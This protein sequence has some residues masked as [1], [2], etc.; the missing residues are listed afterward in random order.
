[1][2]GTACCRGLLP[3]VGVQRRVS[4]RH[5]QRT[6]KRSVCDDST[7]GWSA[8]L[9]AVRGGGLPLTI[10]AATAL[11]SSE[12][13]HSILECPTVA[14]VLDFGAVAPF[15]SD[16]LVEIFGSATPTPE[17]L[18]IEIEQNA[19]SNRLERWHGRVV[20]GY[21]PDGVPQTFHSSGSRG[22]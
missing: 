2:S 5:D 19:F 9:E 15:R 3:R 20:I 14:S 11:A 1:M 4:R 16:E 21:G 22:D 6:R 8:T 17:R 10:E 13:L 18:Q 12:G 7:P